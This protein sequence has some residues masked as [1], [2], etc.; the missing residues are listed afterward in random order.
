MSKFFFVVPTKL[1]NHMLYRSEKTVGIFYDLSKAFDCVN[2]SILVD[3]FGKYGI[4][5]KEINWFKSYLGTRKQIIIPS[6]LESDFMSNSH[7]NIL[8]YSILKHTGCIEYYWFSANGLYLNTSAL[9]LFNFLLQTQIL[10][11]T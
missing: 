9:K 11:S 1:P 10:A 5:D 3:K 6:K 8:E 4:T 7:D 2:H